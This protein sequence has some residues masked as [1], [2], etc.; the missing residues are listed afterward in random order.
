MFIYRRTIR[1]VL[2]QTYSFIIIVIL[3]LLVAPF[4]VWSSD[5]L[6]RN[7]VESLDNLSQS[8]Q[9]KLDL[10]IKRID[11]VSLN[12]LY[13]NLVKDRFLK[14]KEE[15]GDSTSNSKD[16]ADILVAANGPALPVMQINLYDFEGNM[17]GSGIDNRRTQVN[18]LNK[19][20]Y[21]D[22]LENKTGK[23][24]T[25]PD[26]DDELSLFLSAKDAFSISLV[27][28]FFDANNTPEGIVEVKQDANKLFASIKDYIKHNNQQ[29]VI[30]YT[31]AGDIIYPIDASEKQLIASFS[32]GQTI[33]HAT[34]NNIRNP[35]TNEK[36]IYSVSHS[37]YTGW[38]IALVVSE[39]QLLGPLNQFT[40]MIAVVSLVILLLALSLSYLAAKR[41]TKPIARMHA[42][43]KSTKLEDIVSSTHLKLDSGL[44]ELDRLQFAFNKMSERLKDSMDQ[45]LLSQMQEMQA[46]MLA[47]QSQMNPHF[48]YNTLTT[49]S[50]MAEENMNE[51]IVTM[52]EN[53][54][55]MLRYISA[56]NSALV[57]LGTELAYTE[58]Y[59]EC[60]KIRH[61][62]N[63]A[64]TFDIEDKLQN[65]PVPKLIIQPLVENSLKHSS[66]HLPPWNIKV[67]GYQEND[68]WFVEVIDNGPGFDSTAIS[69]FHSRI[70]E[71]EKSGRIPGL[72]L[73]GMGL[74]NIYL[75][76]KI[77]YR[78]DMCMQM[79]NLPHGG[80]MVRV[81]GNLKG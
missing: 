47:L 53:L 75:R 45:L 33:P 58:K 81:G 11:S 6:K 8:M 77:S 67:R 48:L 61:K 66:K 34:M 10:E 42:A 32:R 29:K 52:I 28:L 40:K 69:D 78:S 13:S 35:S 36:E 76:L 80:A 60:I 16:L 46:K 14:F 51:Q 21:R 74:L 49:I 25:T 71:I 64:Y 5:L 12:V 65:I 17:F 63:M 7:A 57:P 72:Q 50:I 38:N 23:L 18:L 19:P 15:A 20:W 56:D 54:S 44:N 9:E 3:T 30:V 31:D 62:H 1:S 59:L 79:V 22:V 27:R 39:D 55:L 43:M 26:K 4:Y 73:D 2:F 24:I 68:Q 37:E 70:Q 41:I